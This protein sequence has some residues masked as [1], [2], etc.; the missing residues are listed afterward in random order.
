MIDIVICTYNRIGIAIDLAKNLI[1]NNNLIN[2]VIIVD[3][4]DNQN[5]TYLLDTRIKIEKTTYKNQPLQ[6]YLGYQKSNSDIILF[7]DDD[8]ELIDNEFANKI[9]STFENLNISGIAINFQDK[10]T[11]SSLSKIPPSLFN[12]KSK[13]KKILNWFTGY[14]QQQNGKL[15]LCGIRGKQPLFGG[16]TEI[17]GGGAFAIKR[18]YLY[19]NFNFQLIDLYEQKIGK[20]E[21]VILG[22][23][24]SK[25][26]GLHFM[27]DLLFYHNDQ[28]ISNYSSNHFQFA[29]RVSFS[30]L[31]LSFEKTRLDN[32]SFTRAY[33]HYHWYTLWR[34]LGYMLNIIM[35]P[36]KSRLSILMGTMYGY[37]SSFSFKFKY[38]S[39]PYNY[40][41]NT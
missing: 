30:R 39:T 31:Y 3:S 37:V 12:S 5:Q 40:E 8:M 4:T 34:I 41:T 27:P 7:L 32:Q 15:G 23:T 20:G 18:E 33:L 6:R 1:L 19:N 16:E 10:H 2:N 29:K 26:K 9:M 28:T 17:I 22:Y 35:Q 36:N 24:L 13:I 38:I 14:H 25:Q 11:N 21:D